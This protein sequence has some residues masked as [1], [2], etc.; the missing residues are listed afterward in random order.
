M[1]QCQF[2]ELCGLWHTAV[3]WAASYYVFEHSYNGNLSCK[4]YVHDGI[5]L[6]TNL[7]V[8]HRRPGRWKHLSCSCAL[9]QLKMTAASSEQFMHIAVRMRQAQSAICLKQPVPLEVDDGAESVYTLCVGEESLASARN[10]T[11]IPRASSPWPSH[12]SRLHTNEI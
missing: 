5:T 2:D 11:K 8:V 4:M 9:M 7:E 1:C 12:H 3:S 6:G 10:R